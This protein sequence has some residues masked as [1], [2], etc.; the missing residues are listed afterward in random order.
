MT[1]LQQLSKKYVHTKWVYIDGWTAAHVL[2]GILIAA[3]PIGPK[4][5]G[6]LGLYPKFSL[7][8]AFIIMSLAWELFELVGNRV[9]KIQYFKEPGID[10]FWDLAANII[11][12]Y[13]GAALT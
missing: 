2:L 3:S 4:L 12:F 11:G 9:L 8:T 10:V 5:L 13:I 6:W 7:F 1:I